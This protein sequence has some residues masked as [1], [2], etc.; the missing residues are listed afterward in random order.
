MKLVIIGTGYVGLVSGACFADIGHDVIC[1]DTDPSKVDSVNNCQ[2]PIHEDG[3]DVII[4]RVVLSGKLKAT[5]DLSS[6]IIDADITMIAVGTP[7]DGNLIDLA[8]VKQAAKDIAGVL[9]TAA[10]YHVVCIKST[11]VPGTTEDVVGPILEKYSDRRIGFDLGLAMNPEFL[12]EGTAVND[13]QNPDRIVIGSNN[14]QAAKTIKNLY[15]P[16]VGTDVIFVGL[17]TAEMIKYTANAFLA[18]V[19]SFSNEIGNLCSKID[20]VDVIDVM[21]GVHADRRLSPLKD[22]KRVTPGLMSFL[23]PGTGFGGSCFPKDIKALL[24]YGKNINTPMPILNSVMETNLKQPSIT[25]DLVEKELGVLADKRIAILGLA[26]KPGTDDVRESPALK[27]IKSLIELGAFAIAHDPIAIESMQRDFVNSNL[28]YCKDL[29]EAIKGV[30]AIILVTSWPEYN[31]LN[32]LLDNK[33][34]PII[35]GRRVLDK[36]DFKYYRGIGLNS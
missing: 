33:E 11:V 8:Y 16:F 15:S 32:K 28:H 20:G 31:S 24:S 17:S 10:D 3:L 30:D 1:V 34:I 27:I 22:G 23:H 4:E 5:T 26:F 25:I 36:S 29:N 9:D 14:K 21:K 12:A 6:A 13:F 7:F 19:I 35:D 2:S 18:S